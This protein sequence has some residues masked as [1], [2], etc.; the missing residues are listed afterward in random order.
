M[1]INTK[2]V[3]ARIGSVKNTKKIT[4]AMEMISAVKMRKTVQSAVNTREYAELANNILLSVGSSEQTHPLTI[5]NNSNK[6]L[7]VIITSNRGL[8]GSYNAK[9]LISATNF[10][11]ANKFRNIEGEDKPIEYSVLAI[12]NKSAQFAKRNNLELIGIYDKLSEKPNYT[13]V[14]PISHSMQK[15]FRDEQ[16][17]AVTVIY[18]R[19]ISGLSQLV[20]NKTLLPITSNTIEEFI[21][22]LP[23]GKEVKEDKIE[24]YKYEPA[25]E[26]VLDFL[27]PMLIEVQLYQALLESSASEH[28]SRMIAM[29]NATESAGDMIN[30]LTLEFNKGRQAQ[31]TKEITEIVSGANAV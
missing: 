27:L 18:T 9:V 23:K 22:E 28:S 19:Y 21:E 11:E 30:N 25:K 10:V 4:K 5:S 17:Y 2:A 26:E 1:A 20:E 7:L 29:K 13:D 3:K 6:H 24:D 14:G 31:I 12:G 16:Y 15:L 8:C